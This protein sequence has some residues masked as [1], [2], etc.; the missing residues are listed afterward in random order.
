MAIRVPLEQIV[1]KGNGV[2][3]IPFVIGLDHALLGGKIDR[4]IIS[5]FRSFID[6]GDWNTLCCFAKARF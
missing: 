6:N 4:S 2:L 5:L 1:N 3:R